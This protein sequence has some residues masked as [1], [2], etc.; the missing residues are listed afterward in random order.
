MS[1]NSDNSDGDQQSQ[2]EILWSTGPAPT[3]IKSPSNEKKVDKLAL[4]TSQSGSSLSDSGQSPTITHQNVAAVSDNSI[5]SRYELRD[6]IGEGGMGTVHRA[7][8]KR[9]AREVAIKRIRADRADSKTAQLRFEKEAQSLAQLEHPHIVRIY[10]FAWDAEGPFLVMDFVKGTTLADFIAK[11]RM[12]RD[13]PNDDELDQILTIAIQLCDGLN[14]AHERMVIHRDIKPANVLLMATKP[15]F[16]KLTDFGLAK[17]NVTL[18]GDTVDGSVLGTID[19]MSPEQKK[20]SAKVDAKADQWS[21]AATLYSMLTG[22]TPLVINIV[23]IPSIFQPVLIRAL[24]T[25]PDERFENV[26]ELGKAL[27]NIQ[28]KGL[29]KSKEMRRGK[30]LNPICSADNSNER[31]FCEGCGDPLLANCLNPRCGTSIRIW[32]IFCPEC[33]ANQP[34][35]L[36][37]EVE[38][39][40]KNLEQIDK[41]WES[42]DWKQPKLELN[43]IF[44]HIQ[45]DPRFRNLKKSVEQQKENFNAHEQRWLELISEAYLHWN[46]SDMQSVLR[47][48]EQ[49][50]HGFLE[51]QAAPRSDQ[52]APQILLATARRNFARQT[53][54]LAELDPYLQLEDSELIVKVTKELVELLPNNQQY[55]QL[56][57]ENLDK[58]ARRDQDREKHFQTAVELFDADKI[59]EC[60]AHI[61][62]LGRWKWFPELEKLHTRAIEKRDKLKVINLVGAALQLEEQQ[63]YHEALALLTQLSSAELE[64]RLVGPS[65]KLKPLDVKQRIEGR[66]ARVRVIEKELL[67]SS[68][69][70]HPEREVALLQE[71]IGYLPHDLSWKDWLDEAQSRK[72]RHDGQLESFHVQALLFIESRDFAA[73]LDV[74]RKIPQGQANARTR[75]LQSIASQSI[76]QLRCLQAL[77]D[78]AKPR[79]ATNLT[80]LPVEKDT[81]EY[82]LRL[83]LA[84]QAFQ[85]FWAIDAKKTVEPGSELAYFL[86]TLMREIDTA[87]KLLDLQVAKAKQSMQRGA[88]ETAINELRFFPDAIQNQ[89]ARTVI[90]E[91]KDRLREAKHFEADDDGWDDDDSLILLEDDDDDFDNDHISLFDDPLDDPQPVP[92]TLKQGTTSA[93]SVK[94]IPASKAGTTKP[95]TSS[96]KKPSTAWESLQYWLKQFGDWIFVVYLLPVIVVVIISEH[97]LIPLYLRLTIGAVASSTD[98]GTK[99]GIA[100]LSS[101]TSTAIISYF[102]LTAIAVVAFL[103]WYFFI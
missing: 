49:I 46:A 68:S 95:A 31:K 42:G 87:S 60:L 3:Q 57:D 97:F 101:V 39:Y 28:E 44:D 8:D 91:A 23:D 102:I 16:A 33:G 25:S 66:L 54:L 29:H 56:L 75:E 53:V 83:D 11:R 98:S 76:E 63:R 92:P 21:L 93:S 55:R 59:E 78:I 38:V 20:N 2:R 48:L 81:D 9:L 73:A 1:S 89:A 15:P 24:R 88:F 12:K 41:A 47:A 67:N 30:C 26:D 77:L 17:Q 27:R 100:L 71:I 62:S 45:N 52:V 51:S 96:A 94:A 80:I 99:R 22:E 58:I 72:Q 65:G 18:R 37:A 13:L 50:P 79:L 70:M 84:L 90:K 32:E 86:E 35:L 5:G 82:I 61:Q 40:H 34:T 64:L 7:F 6:F 4:D 36:E 69:E 14:Y 10:D 19:Y 103:V 85:R 74:L 43:E